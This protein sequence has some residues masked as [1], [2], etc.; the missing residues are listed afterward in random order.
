LLTLKGAALMYQGEELGLPEVDLER[1]WIKDPVG[2]LYFPFGKGRDGCRT[3]MPWKS[4]AHEAGF[5]SGDPWLPIPDYHRVRAANVQETDGASVLVHAKHIISVR[6]RHP[7]LARG[8]IEFVEAEGDRILAF[9]REGEGER[10]L[11]V[12]NLSREQAKYTLPHGA[13]AIDIATGE[14]A[15]DGDALTLS[16]RSAAVFTI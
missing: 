1:K 13:H 3:P 15:R 4:E 12:F 10:L 11:C 5:T 8:A 9:T 6:K 7:A 2:D 14:V 16:P